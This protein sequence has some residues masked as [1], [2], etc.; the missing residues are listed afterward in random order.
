MEG[1]IR[2]RRTENVPPWAL[3][4]DRNGDYRASTLF[5]GKYTLK[6][7]PYELPAAVGESGTAKEI[8]FEVFGAD[9]SIAD[10]PFLVQLYPNPSSGRST[11]SIPTDWQED[12]RLRLMD[13]V[14]KVV[15]QSTLSSGT[16]I[17]NWNLPTSLKAFTFYK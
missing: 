10:N 16:R 2:L 12:T 6:A 14:G 17:R 5:P 11:L 1:P 9:G 4:G 15:W 13:K 3:F 8:E 7:T